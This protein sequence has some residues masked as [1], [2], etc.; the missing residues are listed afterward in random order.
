MGTEASKECAKPS[1]AALDAAIKLGREY[2]LNRGADSVK[3]VAIFLDSFAESRAL[4]ARLEEHVLYCMTCKCCEGCKRDC[5]R[6]AVL[7][8]QAAERKGT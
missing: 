1:R 4:A 2:D 3:S 5:V 6:R 7:E 8:R